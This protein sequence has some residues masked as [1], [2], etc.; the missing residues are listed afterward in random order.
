VDLAHALHPNY[1]EKHDAQ[2]QPLLNRGIVLKSNA[3][4]RYAS[5]ARSS[6]VITKICHDHQLPLQNF[7]ARGDIPCGSTIGPIQ[8]CLTGISTVDIGCAQLSMHSSRELAGCKD[9][10]EMCH[11]LTH[12]L[13]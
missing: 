11:V 1:V 9:Y 2:H 13:N 3:G 5:D 4:Q 12:F 6:A 7:V 10:Q 8:A